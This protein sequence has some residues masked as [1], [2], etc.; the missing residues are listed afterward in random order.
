MRYG[1][2]KWDGLI[3]TGAFSEVFLARQVLEAKD[4]A[5]K[6]V[7][8]HHLKG[9]VLDYFKTEVE[10]LQACRHNG[11]ADFVGKFQDPLKFYL[12]FEFC[13]GGDLRYGLSKRGPYAENAVIFYAAQV[14]LALEYLHSLKIMFRGLRPEK[15][16]ID[17]EGYAKL[18]DFGIAKK[19]DKDSTFTLCGDPEYVSPDLLGQQGYGLSVDIWSLGIIVYEL[20]AGYPPFAATT[21]FQ[22]YQKVLK[23]RVDYPVSL[24]DAAKNFIA[25]LLVSNGDLRPTP[26]ETKALPYFITV[27]WKKLNNRQL[28]APFVPI[29]G[30]HNKR[31]HFDDFL[32][33]TDDDD[34]DRNASSSHDDNNH[35]NSSSVFADLVNLFRDAD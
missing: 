23:N 10:L 34:D 25:N 20:L 16:C 31:A 19:L 18:I 24:T 2:F 14:T 15:V 12:I 33:T 9:N 5:V 21:P 3:G 4:C 1:D 8:K 22:V 32:T 6:V 7:R 11:I 29:S 28:E 35:G 17:A 27:D 26:L 13:R 30:D